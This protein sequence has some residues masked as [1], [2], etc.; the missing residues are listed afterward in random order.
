MCVSDVD[1]IAPHPVQQLATVAQNASG[2]TQPDYSD[3]GTGTFSVMNSV[4]LAEALVRS[5]GCR[6]LLVCL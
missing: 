5:L 1:L 6:F 4:V 2:R 3:G